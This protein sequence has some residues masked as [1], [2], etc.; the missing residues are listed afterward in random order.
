MLPVRGTLLGELFFIAFAKNPNQFIRLQ[1]R[2][3]WCAADTGATASSPEPDR[4]PAP[5][6]ADLGGG[7]SSLS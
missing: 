3:A 5:T 4:S 6:T 2:T 7:C 1:N